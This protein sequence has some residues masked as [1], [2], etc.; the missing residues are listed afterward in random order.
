MAESAHILG[1][2]M[3]FSS[4][5]VRFASTVSHIVTDLRHHHASSLT[6]KIETQMPRACSRVTV[7]NLCLR[8]VFSPSSISNDW[9]FHMNGENQTKELNV[10]SP[11][12]TPPDSEMLTG[13]PSGSINQEINGV[14]GKKV[15]TNLGSKVIRHPEKIFK[16]PGSVSY[17]R[18]LPYLME[19]ADGVDAKDL[20]NQRGES[21]AAKNR[22]LETE[23]VWQS[24]NNFD[25]PSAQSLHGNISP[26]KK[27]T[28][29][30]G[31]KIS[32]CS[33]RKLFK[34]PGS[35]NYR[36]MLSYL[37][38]NSDGN[39]VTPETSNRTEDRAPATET[40]GAS[41]E[42]RD[43]NTCSNDVEAP[44]CDLEERTGSSNFC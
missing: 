34:V 32:L 5:S 21:M 31:T 44:L 36:R 28:S 13:E 35:V 19:A 41:S 26:L 37:K 40:K 22:L 1:K 17:R 15:G 23:P 11:Q 43:L 18:M 4:S 16:N 10:E 25:K 2:K 12:M 24:T 38:E 20:E 39:P 14:S 27:M 33:K 3:R 7:K 42:A 29:S 30:S 6:G 8:R 9:D